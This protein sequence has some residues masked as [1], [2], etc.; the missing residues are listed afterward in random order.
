MR[1]SSAPTLSG[2]ITIHSCF[3]VVVIVLK[4]VVEN[5]EVRG[6]CLKRRRVV[7][8]DVLKEPLS[9]S[10]FSGVCTFDTL[11]SLVR[12]NFITSW[13]GID[14]RCSCLLRTRTVPWVKQKMAIYQ[15][16]TKCTVRDSINFVHCQILQ[17]LKTAYFPKSPHQHNSS[18]PFENCS[19]AKQ[20]ILHRINYF[21]RP[22]T[23][24]QTPVNQILHVLPM[25]IQLTSHSSTSSAA[26]LSSYCSW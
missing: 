20:S 19:I 13:K 3:V 25:Y 17:T 22:Q 23:T 6:R 26:T 7:A 12:G 16:I 18:G 5:W 21:A 9:G 24:D 15:M 1:S 4:V 14:Y 8:I 2:R 10:G 11:P